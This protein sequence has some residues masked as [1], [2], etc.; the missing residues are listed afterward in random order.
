MMLDALQ[1][2]VVLDEAHD[3][4]IGRYGFNFSELWVH[5]T[6]AEKQKAL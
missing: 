4:L 2:H 1:R 6:V 5:G 3:V